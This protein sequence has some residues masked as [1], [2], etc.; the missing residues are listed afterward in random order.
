MVL[1]HKFSKKGDD[2]T[3]DLREQEK[4]MDSG[5]PEF[6][7]NY[8]DENQKEKIPGDPITESEIAA[9]KPHDKVKI[10]FD[11]FVTLVA[12]HAYEEIFEKHA[13]EDLILSTDLLADLANA[14]EEKSDKKVPIVFIVGVVLGVVVTYLLLKF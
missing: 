3:I 11:K 8:F 1:G 9:I 2:A 13:H 6:Q 5:D 10:K 12:N 7:I 4:E 14:H